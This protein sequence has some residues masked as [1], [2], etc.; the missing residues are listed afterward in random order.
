MA[1]AVITKGTVIHQRQKVPHFAYSDL[2]FTVVNTGTMQY[3]LFDIKGLNY[4]HCIIENVSASGA[5]NRLDWGVNVYLHDHATPDDGSKKVVIAADTAI[6]TTATAE[7]ILAVNAM[8]TTNETPVA[9]T[10]HEILPAARLEINLD[11]EGADTI[12]CNIYIVGNV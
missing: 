6:A 12:T 10:I 4:I 8:D 5:A 1:D 7:F 3:A 11:A 9:P 2:A